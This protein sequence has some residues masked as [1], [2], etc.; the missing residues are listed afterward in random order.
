MITTTWSLT[1][2]SQKFFS[3]GNFEGEIVGFIDVNNDGIPEVQRS[4]GCD[5]RCEAITSIYK[6]TDDFVSVYNH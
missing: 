3:A 6:N 4:I 5:G 1:V 2:Y